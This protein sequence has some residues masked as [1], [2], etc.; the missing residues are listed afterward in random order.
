[1]GSQ[2]DIC[3]PSGGKSGN[4]QVFAQGFVRPFGRVWIETE[5]M[6]KEFQRWL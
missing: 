6:Q 3:L 4:K 1:M 5:F 2:F